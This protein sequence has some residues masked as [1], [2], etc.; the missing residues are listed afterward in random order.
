MKILFGVF[1]W[2]I[3][4]ATRDI[5]L[6]DKLKDE[7]EVHVLSTGNALVLL[8]KRFKDHLQYI[9][10]PSLHNIYNAEGHFVVAFA[11]NSLK[12][13]Y[14]LKR[15]EHI[16]QAIIKKGNYDIVISDCRYDV[17]DKVENSFLINHQLRFNTPFSL[18]R[19]YE[20]YLYHKMKR[21]KKVL[22][23][24]YETG[25]ITDFLSHRLRYFPESRILY[26]GILSHVKK[27]DLPQD[28]DYFI[29]LS[30]PVCP[31]KEL[32]RKIFDQAKAL[33]GKVVIAGGLPGTSEI[34]SNSNI[35]YH[36]FLDQARQ[37]EMMN[38]AKFIIIRS[39]FSTI[40]ELAELEKPALL[41]PSPNQTEQE[42][43]ADYLE[44][45]G[46]FHH[47]NQDT[48]DLAREIPIARSYKGFSPPWKTDTSVK[49][50][51]EEVTGR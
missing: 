12:I 7:H 35:E 3:G 11:F 51:L 13:L 20:F 26:A 44:Q 37:E 2:G 14:S 4:H 17:Y 42:F 28:I 46:F 8:K 31:R 9:D 5:P 38:R 36:A 34:A 43:L 47:A 33:N 32:L 19:L 23:P 39:G 41:I 15:A 1:D 21:Y 24:D 49:K 30:G 50:I 48:L 18:E 40:M 6:L 27:R 45:K 25:S 10:V 16:S 29:S 22:V